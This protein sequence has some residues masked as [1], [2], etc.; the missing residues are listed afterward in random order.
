MSMRMDVQEDG[1]AEHEDGNEDEDEDADGNDEHE[2]EDNTSAVGE[3]EVCELPQS[4][5]PDGLTQD[6]NKDE[7]AGT[8]QGKER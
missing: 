4:A 6:K 3:A 2:D 8:D 1:N 5:S 7:D